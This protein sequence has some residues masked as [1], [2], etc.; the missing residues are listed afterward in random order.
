MIDEIP[1][2]CIEI[3]IK[4]FTRYPSITKVE[5]PYRP[6]DFVDKTIKKYN[7]LWEVRNVDSEGSITYNDVL[8]EYDST[9]ILFYIKNGNLIF[10]LYSNDKSNVVDF[11][12]HNLKKNK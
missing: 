6:E 7:I 12:I 2:I 11:T 9:G 8:I 4:R 10:I 1:Q 5:P 3:F